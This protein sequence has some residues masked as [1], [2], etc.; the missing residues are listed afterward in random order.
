MVRGAET[1]DTV[2]ILAL[3]ACEAMGCLLGIWPPVRHSI[4]LSDD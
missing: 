3:L 4:Q 2:D 1:V